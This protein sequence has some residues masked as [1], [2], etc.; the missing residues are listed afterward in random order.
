M[1]SFPP[2]CS[3]PQLVRLYRQPN[4]TQSDG[5]IS[6]KSTSRYPALATEAPPRPACCARYDLHTP[7]LGE[8]D[9]TAQT[10]AGQRP[11][12][13]LEIERYSWLDNTRIKLLGRGHA[14]KIKRGTG[15]K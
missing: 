3:V 12:G 7:A 13:L 5:L 11:R 9:I 1:T 4:L 2:K 15:P 10:Q 14:G 6:L 8:Y